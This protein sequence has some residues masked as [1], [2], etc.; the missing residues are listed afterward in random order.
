M[1]VSVQCRLYWKNR[2][3]SDKTFFP[4]RFCKNGKDSENIPVFKT[5]K[6][7]HGIFRVRNI[8]GRF[9]KLHVMSL[10]LVPDC[11][12]YLMLDFYHATCMFT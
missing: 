4:F 7:P 9:L 3:Q 1:C 8:V 2:F 6:I 10:I 12:I 5:K 11:L